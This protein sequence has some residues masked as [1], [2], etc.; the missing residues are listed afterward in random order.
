MAVQYQDNNPA[1]GTPSYKANWRSLLTGN[2]WSS[3]Q[4]ASA[5]YVRFWVQEAYPRCRFVC[6]RSLG[7]EARMTND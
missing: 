7:A 6:G 4:K 5:P 1:S 2:L 3:L